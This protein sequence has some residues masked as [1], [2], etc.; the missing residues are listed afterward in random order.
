MPQR[1]R[2]EGMTRKQ[3]KAGWR[4][5]ARE[6][7]VFANREQK[8]ESNTEIK[9]AQA[10]SQLQMLQ[11]ECG[12]L[13]KA[14]I[15]SS[16]IRQEILRISH[17]K[18]PIP[19]WLI[20]P[21]TSSKGPGVPC[22]FASDWHWGEIVDS[23]QV[24]GVN[25]YDIATA[26]QRAKALIQN[27]ID[28]LTQHMVNPHYPGIVFALGGD[29]FSGDIHEELS[30]T[31]EA[32]IMPLVLDLYGVLVE[33]IKTLADTFGAVF[34]PCVTG[35]HSR[36]TQKPMSKERNH[37]SFDWLLYSLLDKYFEA[38]NRITFLIPEGTDALFRIYGHTYCL[39]HGDQFRGG[40]GMIGALGPIIR[41]DH[42]KRS[43]NG[44]IGQAYDTLLLGHWHQL[45]QMQRL[46]VNGSLIGYSEYAASGN[47]GFEPPRQALWLTHPTNGITFQMPVLV[48]KGNANPG[49]SWV[50][51][52]GAV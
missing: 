15:S 10:E 35:N 21:S 24:G 1:K 41:G 23:G 8:L 52:P 38:D 14:A 34:L 13:K 17:T 4:A 27:T 19:G 47:F 12:R 37:L 11:S 16:M 50:S 42:R 51:I 20:K 25:S 29:L 2:P 5:R 44:Q 39:T 45:I 9:L 43:R 30:R 46:I 33:C 6:N 32:P 48:E 40:D 28:L 49:V 36:I 3:W 22:L 7:R 18:P 31:N 26:H